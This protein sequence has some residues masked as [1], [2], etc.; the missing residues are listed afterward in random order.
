MAN[1]PSAEKRNRQSRKRQARNRPQRSAV[2][3]AV[4]KLRGAIAAGDGAAARASLPATLGV[5]DSAAQKGVIHA[6]AA[7]RTKSRLTQAV[8]RL[9]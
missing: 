8:N 5:V 6:N 3:S 7:A 9:G 2:R 1:T 4:R